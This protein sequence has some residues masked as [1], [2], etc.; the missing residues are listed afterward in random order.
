MAK[1]STTLNGTSSASIEDLSAQ[2][3][4]LKNDLSTLTQTL[5]DYGVAKTEEVTRSAKIKAEQLRAAGRETA[6]DAQLQAEE[7]VRTQP[8]TALGIAAGLGFLVGMFTAR[9]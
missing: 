9:R 4:I 5:S 8:A 3:E 7:F 1:P 6:A 2:I